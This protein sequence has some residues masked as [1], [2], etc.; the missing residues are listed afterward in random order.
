M[1][2]TEEQKKKHRETLK[3]RFDRLAAVVDTPEELA[4]LLGRAYNTAAVVQCYKRN[5]RNK[6]ITDLKNVFLRYGAA[7]VDY[8]MDALSKYSQKIVDQSSPDTALPEITFKNPKQVLD[9]KSFGKIS[10]DNLTPRH[11]AILILTDA[12]TYAPLFELRKD[13]VVEPSKESEDV[14]AE[15]EKEE[16]PAEEVKTK[17]FKVTEEWLNKHV[18]LA[19]S[20][21]QVGDV[22]QVDA[23]GNYVK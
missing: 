18:E 2:Y 6:L 23:E 12:K 11:V 14:T 19:K 9:T 21:V 20:G 1:V 8:P 16:A 5:L 17:D 15:P 3:K 10:A 13:Y 4:Q 7:K 22:V